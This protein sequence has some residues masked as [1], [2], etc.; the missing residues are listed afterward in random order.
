MDA[1]WTGTER[2]H[3][4]P[5]AQAAGPRREGEEPKLAMHGDEKS[6]L[7]IVAVKPANNPGRPDAE[8]AEP[9]AGAEGNA[10]QQR[11][12]RAQVCFGVEKGPTWRVI[13]VQKGPLPGW[14]SRWLPERLGGVGG[15]AGGGDDRE[16]SAS[17]FH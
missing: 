11:T 10:A 17:V 7:A 16:N 15:D 14:G 3:P 12:R 13:G 4:W 9:R 5:V 2:S 6:D 1:S 8:R